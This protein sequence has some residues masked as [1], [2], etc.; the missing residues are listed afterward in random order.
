MTNVT[1]TT[2]N[3]LG[4]PIHCKKEPAYNVLSQA[5]FRERA[6]EIF[7]ILD[8]ILGRSLGAYGAPTIIS[9]FPYAHITK[10][11]FTIAKNINFEFASAGEEIDRVIAGMAVDICGRLNYAV[12]DGTTS[13][14]IATNQIYKSAVEKFPNITSYRARDIMQAFE[15]VK[16]RLVEELTK[17]ATPITSDNLEETIR[18]IVSISSNGDE[19][20]T[21]MIVN[22]YKE[23]GFPA[24]RCENSDATKTYCEIRKAYTSK[25]AIADTI[26]INNDDKTAEH[27]NVDV[28]MFDHIVK[29]DTYLKILRPLAT[30]CRR[31]GRH[32]LCIA[33]SYDENM[34]QTVIRKELND[35]YRQT[36][37]IT[38]ILCNYPHATGN[39]K[40]AIA[41]LAM[42]LNTTLI[43]KGIENEMLDVLSTSTHIT[44]KSLI[45]MD[46]RGIA[47]I[48]IYQTPESVD[49]VP[50]GTTGVPFTEEDAIKAGENNNFLLR[51]GFANSFKGSVRDSIF[52]AKEYDKNLYEKYLDEAKKTLEEVT[53]KYEILG[54]F[55]KDV[56]DAQHRY[57]SL[58]MSNATIYVGGESQLSRDLLRD[59]VDD[60]VRAAESAFEY[61]YVQGCNVTLSRILKDILEAPHVTTENENSPEALEYTVTCILQNAFR[62]VYKRVLS[63][64]FD[65]ETTP[66]E[67]ID[68]IIDKSIEIGQVFDLSCMDYTSNVIN[69]VKTDIEI[70]TATIDLLKML[71][72]G[73]Q[74]II[75]NYTHD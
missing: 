71:L 52:I 72:T 66:A 14:I 10:D 51:L 59:A 5:E 50:A 9:N 32:L 46:R 31:A 26:Y 12:G 19:F 17:A 29:R 40:K 6:K 65:P 64:A 37:D 56:Y 7:Q 53:R 39:D 30:M 23:L 20:I 21:D 48:N 73:N 67:K 57:T 13:A 55:S 38:L 24:I 22:A 8:E 63:N 58:M 18:N 34:I 3:E 75:A 54:T 4:N 44:V 62:E 47:G 1:E 45:N 61:G 36:K 33:P 27:R 28:I 2:K 16:E 74:V 42:L 15:R 70:L 25:V 11:G 49:L 41:D 43:D 60:A 69:S 68:E 35:E